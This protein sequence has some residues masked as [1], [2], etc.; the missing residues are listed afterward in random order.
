MKTF[1]LVTV[2]LTLL[3]VNSHSGACASSAL[4][5][6]TVVKTTKSTRPITHHSY[7]TTHR[8][9][10]F[11]NFEYFALDFNQDGNLDKVFSHQFLKGER[12]FA[13]RENCGS[14]ELVLASENYSA[15][16]LFVIDS[17]G[18][19]PNPIKKGLI[20]YTYFNGAGG[21]KQEIHLNYTPPHQWTVEIFRH[22]EAPSTQLT[23]SD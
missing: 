1:F 14:Y 16:G 15:G 3:L 21:M 8:L 13:F 23:P 18:T 22:V 2:A 17:I 12:L 4:E 10:N 6:E 11:Q 19:M 5:A 20:I 7:F 9:S